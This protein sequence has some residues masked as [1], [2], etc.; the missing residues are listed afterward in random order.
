MWKPQNSRPTYSPMFRIIWQWYSSW[1]ISL[2]CEWQ[3][4][5]KWCWTIYI[6]KNG[7]NLYFECFIKCIQHGVKFYSARSQ[8][9][10]RLHHKAEEGFDWPNYNN[11][12]RWNAE[13]Y[14]LTCQKTEESSEDLTNV[15]IFMCYKQIIVE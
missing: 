4:K 12:R 2:S 10:W 8:F 15:G 6:D 11:N 7:R 1:N 13:S 3:K 9:F 5:I 14:E